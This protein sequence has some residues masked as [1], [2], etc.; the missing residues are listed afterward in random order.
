MPLVAWVIGSAFA[1]PPEVLRAVVVMAALPVAQ[2][3]FNNAQQY[4]ASV[5]V[6]SDSIFI[7][8]IGSIPV[9]LIAS[10]VL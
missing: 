3:V 8:T 5:A 6:T 1:L 9:L 10:V 4:D 2:N 7:T